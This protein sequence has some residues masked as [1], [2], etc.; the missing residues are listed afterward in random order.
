MSCVHGSSRRRRG[1]SLMEVTAVMV[2]VGIMAGVAI[3]SI[4]STAGNRVSISARQLLSDLTYA[5]QRAIATGT[6][7]WVVFDE[8][9][10]TW[11]L[12]EGPLATRTPIIDPATGEQFMQQLGTG[13]FVGVEIVSAAIDGN[14]EIGFDWLGRPLNSAENALVAPAIIT[15]TGGKMVIIAIGHGFVIVV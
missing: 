10:E 2:V 3:V 15:L 1:F 6:R 8:N 7:T 12:F 11:T 5:R 9:A 13:P 4:S 14:V